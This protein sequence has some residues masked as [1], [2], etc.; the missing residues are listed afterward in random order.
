METY[1]AELF[2]LE[3]DASAIVQWF[4]SKTEVYDNIK[5][6]SLL[7][8]IKVSVPHSVVLLVLQHASAC[9]LWETRWKSHQILERQA[10]RKSRIEW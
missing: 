6:V 8:I 7:L 4:S 10:A 1:N 2:S 3:D 5:T 9:R